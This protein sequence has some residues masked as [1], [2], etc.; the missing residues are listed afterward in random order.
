[1]IGIYVM[2]STVT[3]ITVQFDSEHFIKIKSLIIYGHDGST[4]LSRL[5]QMKCN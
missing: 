5:V 4:G 3:P 1:M 2:V